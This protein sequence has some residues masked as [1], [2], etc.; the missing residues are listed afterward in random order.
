MEKVESQ[1]RIK[2]QGVAGFDGEYEL[3]QAA[4]NMDDLSL[5]KR[6]AGVRAAEL[7]EA[8]NA[9]DHE[10]L[11]AF[12]MV[13]L[14]QS[15]HPHWAAFERAVGVVSIDPSP[16]ILVQPDEKREEGDE[17]ENPPT[18]PGANGA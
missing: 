5:I 13:A 15:G 12:A 16:I 4:F 11:I 14:R 8:L 6:V 17:G 7:D 2:V 9:G 1:E 3:D 10:V 18:P